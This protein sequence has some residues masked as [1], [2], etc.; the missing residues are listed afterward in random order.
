MGNEDVAIYYVSGRKITVVGCWDHKTQ[1]CCFD[2][3]DI[4]ENE[5]CL[6]LGS[7]FYSMPTR[8]QVMDYIK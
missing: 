6:N 3:Y 1:D 2:F 5:E 7:P 8:D 4:Y